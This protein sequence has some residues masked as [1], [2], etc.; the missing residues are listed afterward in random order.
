MVF[1]MQGVGMLLAP[2]MGVLLLSIMPRDLDAVWRLLVGLAAVPGMVMMYWRCKMKETKAF[3]RSK[4][5]RVSQWVLIRQNWKRLVGT[6]GCWFLFDVTFYAN[7]LFSSVIIHVRC[8]TS[9]LRTV[10]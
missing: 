7:G 4:A 8:R 9:V 6:A 3:A 2:L 1:S 10:P 5:R